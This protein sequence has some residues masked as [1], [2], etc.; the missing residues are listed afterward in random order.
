MEI[1]RIAVTTRIELDMPIM[2]IIIDHHMVVEIELD[3]VPQE[4]ITG[5]NV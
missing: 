4:I 2:L 3:I 1:V 5:H